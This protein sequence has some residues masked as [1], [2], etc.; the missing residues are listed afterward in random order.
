MNRL[1]KRDHQLMSCTIYS[2]RCIDR[3]I[4]SLHI[5]KAKALRQVKNSSGASDIIFVIDFKIQFQFH[6]TIV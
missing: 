4:G 3:F 6:W 5:T 1:I 2:P